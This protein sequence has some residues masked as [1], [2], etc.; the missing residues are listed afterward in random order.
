MSKRAILCVDDEQ[1]VLMS[2]RDQIARNFGNA[3]TYEIAS[4]V[5][6]AW[7][8]IEELYEDGIS[9]LLIV[10]DWLMPNIRGDEFLIEVHR[11]FPTI[12]TIML[13]GQADESAISKT[14]SE[15]NLYACL[16][17]PWTEKEL[18]C[19]IKN[20]LENVKLKLFGG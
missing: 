14:Q 10:S 13:T 12:I 17:K 1:I 9:I 2:L 8:V 19:T 7:E 18:I 16:M 4:S 3:Y 5:E 20:S 6:E 15:A 11:K